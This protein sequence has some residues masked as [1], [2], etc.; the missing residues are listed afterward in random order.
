M[1]DAAL[2]LGVFALAASL[3]GCSVVG[4]VTGAVAGLVTG[5][6]TAN[7]AIGIGVGVAVKAGADSAGKYVSRSRKRNEHDAIAA[8]VAE[9]AVGEM[10]PWA[11][12]QRV[13]GD[14][15]GEVHVVREIASSLT[16]CREVLFSVVD[17]E[18]ESAPR[19][20]FTTTVCQVGERWKWAAAEPAVE[21]WVNL[22]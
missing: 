13:I 2:G 5:A 14:A 8:A 11:V 4:D 1:N 3:A 22:Q 9:T 21:R 6:I 16:L 10:R 15:Y 19:A 20:W 18:G 7:P 12:D 17:G